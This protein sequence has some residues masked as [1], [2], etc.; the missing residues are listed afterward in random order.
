MILDFVNRV[1]FGS[2]EKIVSEPVRK[3][4]SSL[5]SKQGVGVMERTRCL[6]EIISMT[7]RF[8]MDLDQTGV[9][10]V[11]AATSNEKACVQI[12]EVFSARH[13]DVF[14]SWMRIGS[15]FWDGDVVRM[16]SVELIAVLACLYE[17]CAP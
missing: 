2:G 15:C 10:A 14:D 3:F 17:K 5:V 1:P 11:M 16:E 8:N 9:G 12:I 13:A 7:F 4:L 6:S